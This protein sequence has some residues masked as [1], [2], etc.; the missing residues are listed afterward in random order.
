MSE[1]V[2]KVETPATCPPHEYE[3]IS[4][5]TP[6]ETKR[7]NS[8]EAEALR[9][10]GKAIREPQARGAEF[11]NKSID[12]NMQKL[13]IQATEVQFRCKICKKDAIKIDILGK[14]QIAESQSE[15]ARN[16]D[17]DKRKST[18]AKRMKAIQEMLNKQ[19]GQ[20]KKPLSKIDKTVVGDEELAKRTCNRR[21][22]DFEFI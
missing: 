19:S 9:S 6:E 7:K 21:G 11:A 1:V 22:L 16:I 12:K 10:K 13:D 14:E 5:E 15:S 4:R 8:A 2:E 17:T 20:T 3:E 18:Q